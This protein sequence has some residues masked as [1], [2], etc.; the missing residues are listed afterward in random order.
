MTI[1]VAL[2]LLVVAA[3]SLAGDF[4]ERFAP[5]VGK[6]VHIGTGDDMLEST[7]TS[8]DGDHFCVTVHIPDFEHNRCYSMTAVSFIAMPTES[9]PFGIWV[10]EP[11]GKR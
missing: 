7:L 3:N 1:R 2:V 9:R 11:R 8:V 4:K 6:R 10:L 5:Y